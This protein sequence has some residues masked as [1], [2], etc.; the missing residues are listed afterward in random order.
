MRAQ[1]T[2]DRFLN[3]QSIGRQSRYTYAGIL[4]AFDA[5]VLERASAAGGLTIGVLRAW[6]QQEIQR[7]PLKSVVHRTCV[8]AHYLD[9]R[10]ATGG[11]AHLQAELRAQYGRL[12]NRSFWRCWRTTM[13]APCNGCGHCRIGAVFLAQ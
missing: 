4:R 8:I 5:F 6:L 7:S 3:T 2:V 9:W 1:G 10:T 12:L 11:R 13:R